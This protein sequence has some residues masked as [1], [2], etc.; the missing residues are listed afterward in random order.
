MVSMYFKIELCIS[1]RRLL[2]GLMRGSSLLP[3]LTIVFNIFRNKNKNWFPD[4]LE[5]AD[6]FFLAPEFSIQKKK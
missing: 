2:K 6:V 5:S 4:P 1:L 3:S